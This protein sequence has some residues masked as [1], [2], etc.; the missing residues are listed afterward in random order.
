MRSRTFTTVGWERYLNPVDN[1]YVQ[2]FL[3]KNGDQ[4]LNQIALNI[5]NAIL[6]NK[7][8]IAFVVHSNAQ[9]VVVI[10]KSDYLEVLNHCM[11]WFETKEDYEMCGKIQK[12][13]EEFNLPKKVSHKKIQNKTLI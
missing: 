2:N 4:V 7:D 8:S 1:P 11:K 10:P 13:K 6:L 3:D 12:F 9:S 5:H